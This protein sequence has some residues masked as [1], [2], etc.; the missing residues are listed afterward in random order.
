MNKRSLEIIT[1]G[2]LFVM[3]YSLIGGALGWAIFSTL[4][5][6][7]HILIIGYGLVSAFICILLSFLS[8]QT[9]ETEDDKTTV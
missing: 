2:L 7:D 9:W 8:S 3:Y 6:N 1:F 5:I 4:E